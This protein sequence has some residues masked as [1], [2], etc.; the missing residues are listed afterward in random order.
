MVDRT[1]FGFKFF[2]L[3]NRAL[4]AAAAVL[5]VLM[6]VAAFSQSAGAWPLCVAGVAC[7]IFANLDRISAISASSSGMN[8]ALSKAEISI[9]QLTRLV[10]MSAVLQLATVQRL[11]RWG[12][13]SPAE[14]QKF[15]GECFFA[16][17]RW[18]LR[19]GDSELRYAPWDR[20]VLLDDVLGITGGSLI[21]RTEGRSAPVE[22][23]IMD[24]WE[25]FVSYL[26]RILAA[27]TAYYNELRTHLSLDKDSPAHG[28]VQRLGQ[29]TA[30][31]ILGGLHHQCR[32]M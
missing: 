31:P 21:P 20:F 2:D 23:A 7:M 28:P 5:F 24:E 22:K 32:R 1:Y 11:G 10:R 15:G 13:F 14:K 16:S 9:A 26:R 29:I 12:G 6:A 19:A 25:G 27:N 18:G 8:I 30:R 3:L 4:W 17:R